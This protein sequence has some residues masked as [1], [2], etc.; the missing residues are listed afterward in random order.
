MSNLPQQSQK[1]THQPSQFMTRK[2]G[3][4]KHSHRERERERERDR[5]ADKGLISEYTFFLRNKLVIIPYLS[6]EEVRKIDAWIRFCSNNLSQHVSQ[7]TCQQHVICFDFKSL[8]F[9]NCY[10][11]KMHEVEQRIG[12]L[13]AGRRGHYLMGQTQV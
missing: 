9:H 10:I 11:V 7:V 5:E 1:I 8:F 4:K 3:R 6:I 13:V 2:K 12:A